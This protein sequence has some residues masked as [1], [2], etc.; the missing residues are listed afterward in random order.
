[1]ARRPVSMLVRETTMDTSADH[2]ITALVPTVELALRLRTMFDLDDCRFEPF[3]FDTQLPRIEPGRIVLPASEPGIESWRLDRGI[4]LPV[5][6]GGLLV[7]RFVLVPKSPTSGAALSPHERGEA[8][9]LANGIA[10]IVA[11]AMV[12]S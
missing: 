2:L 4:E 8:I 1:M 7:G 6:A 12:A 9:E 11:E 10:P 3:P 5:R